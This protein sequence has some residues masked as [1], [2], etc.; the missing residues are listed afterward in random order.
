MWENAGIDLPMI[1]GIS[2]TVSSGLYLCYLPV[3]SLREDRPS[4]TAL[5][6][7][8]SKIMENVCLMS[9]LGGKPLR[10]MM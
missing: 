4:L 6:E 9:Q 1:Y 5:T 8:I 3:F 7:W 10:N 2:L